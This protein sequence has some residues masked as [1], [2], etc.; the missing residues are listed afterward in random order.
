MIDMGS[1]SFRLVVFDYTP[2]RWWRRSDEIYD[3]VRIG[4]GLLDRGSLSPER[5]ER[6]LEVMV[7]YAHFCSASGIPAGSVRAVATSAIRSQGRP[8]R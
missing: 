5:V 4:A 8:L 3:G 7:V 6:A 2:D 1:N